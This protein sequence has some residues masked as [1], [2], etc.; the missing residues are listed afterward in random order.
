MILGKIFGKITTTS[1][2][3]IV[4]KETRKFE[5]VQVLHKVYDY[6]LCQVLEIERTDK[7]IA[8]CIVLGY[9]DKG[10]IKPIR[11][12][13]DQNSEVLKA[14]DDFIKD[15]INLEKSEK[16]AFIGRL[17]GK[18][19]DVYLDLSKLLT[20]HVAVLA[21]SGAGKSYTVGVL[22]EEIIGKKVPII[23]IDPHGEYGVLKTPTD[24][25][26]QLK[27]YGISPIGF[28]NIYEYGD[29]KL[30]NELRP[31]RLN[32]NL[33]PSE[34]TELMPGKLSNTQM[35]LLYSL[36]K[37]IDKVNFTNVLLE[38]DKEE[39]NSKWAI[40]NN[41]E[42]LNNLQIFGDS[43][44]DYNELIQSGR[45]SIINLKGIPPDVQEIIVYKLM[46][47]LFEERKKDRIPPFFTIIEEAHNYCPERSFGEAKS[48]KILRTVAS[49]GRKFGLG[50][51]IVSQRPA[52]VDK[53][54][55]SQCTTQIILKITNPNDL[56]A[57]SNS[58]EGI[59]AESES[60]IRNLAIG[61]ALVTGIVDMPLFVTIRPRRTMHGGHATD[62]LDQKDEAFFE[63]A[64]KFE[65]KD[66][67][68]IIRPK[69]TAKD[70]SIMN[71]KD[72][73]EIKEILVPGFLFLCQ[74]KDAEYNLLVEST[75]GDVVVDVDNFVT[76]SLPELGTLSSE[77]LKLL[78]IGFKMKS[79]SEEDL[80]KKGLLDIKETTISLTTKGFFLHE[81]SRYKISDRYI[82]SQL[83]KSACFAKIEFISQ[84]FSEKLEQNFTIDLVKEKLSKFTKVKDQR[85]CFILRH[86]L[87]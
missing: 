72:I 23:V 5:F 54:V 70:I 41:L 36:L 61:T 27:N 52:R 34:I 31:L 42:Y 51:C 78:Q 32:N 53:S 28:K 44:T 47:D 4:E 74:D 64:D 11:I 66:L 55:L 14:E 15:I 85:E 82:L 16:G 18:N 10:I 24:D 69:V 13:F 8:K 75:C 86:V 77:E 62:I 21:K 40:V 37:H 30:N 65:E 81:G 48:S 56:K 2:Q 50:L 63:K 79:F 73:S 68:P 26:L 58:V 80:L 76:K 39:N 60:E 25:I 38:L 9:K 33:T 22:I 57:I 19:I 1:F 20:K 12:P 59:T 43:F 6:V 29:A 3:F 71:G 87:S 46:K 67:L 35:G 45:C 83:S 84:I 7:D 49:E 17:E